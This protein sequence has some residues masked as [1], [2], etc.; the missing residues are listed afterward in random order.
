[1]L[2]KNGADIDASQFFD[3]G[4]VMTPLVVAVQFREEEIVTTLL[5][6]GADVN[7]TLHVHGECIGTTALHAA[8]KNGGVRIAEKL[9]AAGANVNETRSYKAFTPLML[10]ATFGHEPLVRLLLAQRDIDTT[11]RDVDGCDCIDVSSS[12]AIKQMII[13]H[14]NKP[15]CAAVDCRRVVGLRRCAGCRRVRFCSDECQRTAWKAHKVACRKA[16]KGQKKK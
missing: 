10:A 9:I 1:M 8:C 14:R 16:S 13:A 4:V 6:H 3:K 5:E 11:H 2:L 12:R 15:T 7:K